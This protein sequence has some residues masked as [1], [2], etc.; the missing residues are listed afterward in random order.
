MIN[1]ARIMFCDN[2]HGTGDICFP[3]IDKMDS[4]DIKQVLIKGNTAKELRKEA[5]KAGW[6][7]INGGDYCPACMESGV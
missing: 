5:R 6:G 2:E 7:V 3:D 4:F 1:S